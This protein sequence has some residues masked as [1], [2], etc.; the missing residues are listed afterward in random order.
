MLIAYKIVIVLTAIMHVIGFGMGVFFPAFMAKQFGVEYNEGLHRMTVHFGLL[1]M[2]FSA[3]LIL[4]A[5][6][7]FKGKIEGIL[8][9]VI[10]GWCMTIAAI[11]D[12][13]MVG[14]GVDIPLI[15]M[16]L[17]TTLTAHLALKG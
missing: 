2:I 13:V 7:T 9:G 5:Y 15:V 10:G 14:Q 8:L 16:G 4:A 1:L 6:W 3:F 11:L 17:L 12:L